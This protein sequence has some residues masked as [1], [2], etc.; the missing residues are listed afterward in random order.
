MNRQ[1]LLYT[2]MEFCSMKSTWGL[3]NALVKYWWSEGV[4]LKYFLTKRTNSASGSVSSPPSTQWGDWAACLDFVQERPG[5]V[6]QNKP[7]F[8][9][10]SVLKMLQNN[11]LTSFSLSHTHI[12]HIL[13]IT[14][15]DTMDWSKKIMFQTDLFTQVQLCILTHRHTFFGK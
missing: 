7:L 1:C 6:T 10:L 12:V 13:T 5:Y 8:P 15:L 9:H 4:P 14:C 2:F 11:W 3:D